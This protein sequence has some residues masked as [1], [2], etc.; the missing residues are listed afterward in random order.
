MNFWAEIAPLGEVVLGARDWLAVAFVLGLAAAI[1]AAWSYRQSSGAGWL[2]ATCLVLKLAAIALLMLCLLEPMYVG[3]RPK[4]GSNLFL[5]VADNSR[6]LQLKNPGSSQSRGEAIRQEVAADSTWLVRLAQD[7]DVRKYTFDSHVQPTQDFSQLNFAGEASALTNTLEQLAER[8][9]GQPVAGIMLLTDGNTT[10]AVVKSLSDPEL[11]PIYPV[12][13]ASQTSQRD[14]AVANV[15]V[16]QT[17]FEAAPVTIAA[18]ISTQ[19]LAGKQVVLRVLDESQQELQRQTLNVTREGETLNHRFLIKPEKPGVS[20]YQIHVAL[21]G[22]EDRDIVGKS[23]EATLANNRRFATVDRGGGPYRVLYIAGL[24]NWEFKFLRRAIA[25]DDEVDLVGLLRVAKKEPKFNFLSRSDESTNPLFRGFGNKN[26]EQAEQ[27]D[28]PVLLRLGTEDKDELRGGF[29]KDA[30]DLFRY[31]AVIL[32]D[33]EA[34]FFTQDQL[35]L[36]QQFVSQ[37]GGGLLMMGGKDSYGEGG[38]ARTP[39]SDLLPVYLDRSTPEPSSKLQLKLTREG[40]LQPWVRVRSNEQDEQ[41]RLVSMPGFRSLNRIEAIKPGA[42]VL[43][44]VETA[45]GQVRPALAVQPFGR[46]RV[47]ALLLGDLWRWDLRRPDQAPSDLE[48]AWRQTVRWLVADVPQAVEVETKTTSGTGLPPREII[49]RARDRNFRPLDNATVTITIQ[50]PDKRELSMHADSSDQ[51][52]G[53]Y[54]AL[55]VPRESGVYRANISVNA[56]DGTTVGSRA[57]GWAVE[58]ETEEF[59]KLTG[60]SGLLQRLATETG[61]EVIPLSGLNRF[62][63]SLP[64]RKIPQVETWSYPL[65]HQW[66]V[67][68]AALACL[69]GEWGL[70]R[71]KG[72]A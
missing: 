50:T 15:A 30:E 42:S 70:R 20:F 71:W 7:F 33:I 66:G 11:P 54:S 36:L 10:D 44:E 14:A 60:N 5:V 68:F 17:N 2:R 69:V 34:A 37:R 43:A 21:P 19:A 55:F 16:S 61:G 18:E 35:S 12:E 72:L 1:F 52:A 6:S 22:E 67:L 46:G 63:T 38:Y 57:T 29:P 31:H 27:Y 62:V 3:Q 40:W 48:K 47:G 32:D 9:R 58:P 25:K 56:P 28:E 41:E 4:P 26:D 53:E 49:V 45:D 39:I 23:T 13:I 24:P 8:Y 51:A 65:W 64:N 59:R